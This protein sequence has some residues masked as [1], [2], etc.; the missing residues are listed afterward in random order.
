MWVCILAESEGF[1]P[2][3]RFP[4]LR[5]SKPL[6]STTQPTLHSEAFT[7]YKKEENPSIL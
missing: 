3:V 6:L 7:V 4:G 5:F 2:P 1:E